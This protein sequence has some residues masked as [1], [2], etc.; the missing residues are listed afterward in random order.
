M[1]TGASACACASGSSTVTA[2]FLCA[3]CSERV[4]E[5][6]SL[7]CSGVVPQQPPMIFTPAHSRRRAY[8]AMYSGEQR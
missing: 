8:C 1:G 5:R 6:I 4:S 3:G 7:M 2:S